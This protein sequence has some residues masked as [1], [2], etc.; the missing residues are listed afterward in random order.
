MSE[1][2]DEPVEGARCLHANDGRCW[3]E[4]PDEAHADAV[5]IGTNGGLSTSFDK[6]VAARIN[7]RLGGWWTWHTGGP[8]PP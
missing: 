1:C 5:T 3:R 6:G 8:P 4:T 7:G 2:T